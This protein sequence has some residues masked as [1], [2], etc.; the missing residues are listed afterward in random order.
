MCLCECVRVRVF[1][2]ADGALWFAG[3]GGVFV[4]EAAANDAP[5]PEG[6]LEF[7]VQQGETVFASFGALCF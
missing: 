2:G 5:G 3:G 6:A 7:G 1:T 4:R